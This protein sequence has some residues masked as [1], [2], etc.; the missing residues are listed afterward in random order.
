MIG[1]NYSPVKFVKL[2]LNYTLTTYSE[3]TMKNLNTIGFAAI[4][5][6]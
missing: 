2:Q 6:F 3:R 1:V 4:A 5:M